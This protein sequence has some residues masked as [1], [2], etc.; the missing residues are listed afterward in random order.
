MDGSHTR[1]IPPW[2]IAVAVLIGL[3]VTVGV[4]L[5]LAH[6][7]P[8]RVGS[9]TFLPYEA[10]LFL[11]ALT[12]LGVLWRSDPR[13]RT[14]MLW[15]VVSGTVALVLIVGAY[16]GIAQN[17]VLGGTGVATAKSVCIGI[18]LAV[19]VVAF[20]VERITKVRRPLFTAL[21]VGL[22]V[23]GFTFENSY[24]LQGSLTGKYRQPWNL[25]HYYMG[26][27]YFHEVGYTDLYSA[28]LARD[29][30]WM[31]ERPEKM[32]G[33]RDFSRVRKSRN[34]H[35]YKLESRKS[36]VDAY[37]NSNFTEARWDEFGRDLRAIRPWYKGKKWASVMMDL[38]YNPAPPWTVFG[39]PLAN[40]IE[41]KSR[42]FWLITNSDLPGHILALAAMIWAFGLRRT[43]IAVLWVTAMPF[44]ERY[45]IGAFA[46]YDWLNMSLIALA[47]YHKGWGKSSGTV[48]AWAAMTR[49]FPGFLALPILARALWGLIRLG[50]KAM[51]RRRLGFGVAFVLACSVLFGA[52]H[53]TGRGAHTWLEWKEN[54]SLHSKLHPTTSSKRVGVPRLVFHTALEHNF[55]STVKG[56]RFDLAEQRVVR[57]RVIQVL[58]LA[59]L[60]AAL[61]RRRD[62]DAMLLM[63]FAVFLMLC[64]SRYYASVWMI[65]FFLGVRTRAD[66]LRWPA[67]FA[68]LALLTIQLVFF[69][70][71][72]NAGQ[73]YLLNYE[74]LAM[75]TVL[76][77]GYLGSLFVQWRAR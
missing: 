8:G 74:I 47:L 21:L 58:G 31:R 26:S 14:W 73:Y 53:F 56:S 61:L 4:S 35:D 5:L 50:P 18:G 43:A 28:H 54:I 63:L 45:F 60:I 29:D 24:R 13:V 17:V 69:L 59:L 55:W 76:C 68:G 75:F 42:S 33:K 6:L 52:S 2:W 64:T 51:D 27:K 41:V 67:F 34:M 32:K 72:R 1:R 44:N 48:L 36:L 71:Q 23:A 22:A 46:R 70:P 19:W 25:Y 39:T 16:L 62:L 66:I 40:A 57:K 11:G 3:G 12:S 15:T 77:L 20:S 37:D 9:R 30:Q 65:L 49:V 10:G 7:L 38:G